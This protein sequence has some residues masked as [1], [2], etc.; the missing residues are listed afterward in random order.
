MCSFLYFLQT[1]PIRSSRAHPFCLHSVYQRFTTML[2]DLSF[3][4]GHRDGV[5]HSMPTPRRQNL[6]INHSQPIRSKKRVILTDLCRGRRNPINLRGDKNAIL[7]K[8]CCIADMESMRSDS[9]N[10]PKAPP[11]QSYLADVVPRHA[12]QV[13]L[14]THDLTPCR[15]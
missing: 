3:F 15:L 1:L 4:C 12:R 9:S 11:H 6:G 13:H 8:A 5:H 14:H 7:A 10:H 2:T